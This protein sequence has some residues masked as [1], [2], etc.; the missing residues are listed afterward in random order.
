MLGYE[1]TI[2][3]QIQ[4]IQDIYTFLL[5]YL[6]NNWHCML[7]ENSECNALNS[8]FWTYLKMCCVC[9]EMASLSQSRTC[10]LYAFILQTGAIK[11]GSYLDLDKYIFVDVNTFNVI[12]FF[13]MH[14]SFSK[15]QHWCPKCCQYSS[16]GCI[17]HTH[18]IHLACYTMKK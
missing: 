8:L 5:S 1:I 3:I 13:A 11:N 17:L 9:F 10:L 16:W 18:C 6:T 4:Q 12:W 7:V 14:D 15:L 2:N